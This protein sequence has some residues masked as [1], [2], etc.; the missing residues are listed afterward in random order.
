M[1]EKLLRPTGLI[2]GNM[3]RFLRELGIPI[4]KSPD[5]HQMTSIRFG[6]TLTIYGFKLIEDYKAMENFLIANNIN[7]SSNTSEG[8]RYEHHII[9]KK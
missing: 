3:D 2:N 4:S 1:K 9:L 6:I 5:E 7:Y 8:A